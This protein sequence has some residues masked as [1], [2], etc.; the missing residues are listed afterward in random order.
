[1]KPLLTHEV[2]SLDKPSWPVKAYAGQ[3]LSED[4]VESARHWGERLSVP[5][6]PALIDLLRA[7]PLGREQKQA[8]RRWSSLYAVRLLET[9]G[10]DAVYDGEQQRTGDQV[11]AE[12]RCWSA[13]AAPAATAS[14]GS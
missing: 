14:T 8:L 3:P 9:A 2:G 13:V 4:D 5:E 11:R 12:R 6:Y 10:L 1:M 7:G